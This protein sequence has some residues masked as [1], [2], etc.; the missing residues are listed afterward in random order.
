LIIKLCGTLLKAFIIIICYGVLKTKL[1][2]VNINKSYIQ[3]LNRADETHR[4]IKTKNSLQLQPLIASAANGKQEA[5]HVTHSYTHC[6]HV[7]H[8][9]FLAQAEIPCDFQETQNF[10]V[11]GAK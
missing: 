4:F 3:K 11:C 10:I 5:A 7:S 8:S 2:T 6:F 9:E 1:Y